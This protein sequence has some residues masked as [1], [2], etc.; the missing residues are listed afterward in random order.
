MPVRLALG[1]AILT[2]SGATRQYSDTLRRI[3][4][5]RAFR[6]ATVVSA[7][8]CRRRY[9]AGAGNTR[10]H[11]VA[12]AHGLA[13][14]RLALSAD[15][16]ARHRSRRTRTTRPRWPRHEDRG[17]RHHRRAARFRADTRGLRLDR[18]AGA[19]AAVG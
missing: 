13:C 14:T 1:G 2:K 10:A 6:R 12:S 11:A 15:G 17:R 19:R 3:A 8:R 4:A 5:Q 16:L 9:V 18:P 7:L